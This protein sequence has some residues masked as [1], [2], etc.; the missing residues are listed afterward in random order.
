VI[1]LLGD[2][3]IARLE[4]QRQSPNDPIAQSLNSKGE[5][6]CT[7]ER[8]RGQFSIFGAVEEMFVAGFQGWTRIVKSLEDVTLSRTGG[9]VLWEGVRP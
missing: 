4:S 8:A 2:F 1:E 3:A 7:G 9:W 5:S 6:E